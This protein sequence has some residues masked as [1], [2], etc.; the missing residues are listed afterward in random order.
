MIPRGRFPVKVAQG[1]ALQFV[2]SG[3][4]QLPVDSTR[5]NDSFA[6]DAMSP[7]PTSE[8]R[9]YLLNR[10]RPPDISPSEALRALR[11]YSFSEE[12]ETVELSTKCNME[13][14]RVRAH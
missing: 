5:H 12:P 6:R 14:K 1:A 3:G 10:Y 7:A 11:A 9:V 8:P 2:R 13:Y 4:S